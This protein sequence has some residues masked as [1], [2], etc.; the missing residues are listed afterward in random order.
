[1]SLFV[2][3]SYQ[4]SPL[5]NGQMTLPLDNY[6]D[7]ETVWNQKQEVFGGIFND[8]LAFN[9]RSSKFNHEILYNENDLIVLRLANNKHIVQESDFVT[10]KLQHN[11]SC[12]ILIDN[13]ADV[14]NMYIEQNTY[15]FSDV[16]VVCNILEA[17]FN[18]YL[19]NAQLKLKI[20]QRYKPQEFWEIVDSAKKGVGMVRF[21]FQ[22]PN[23]P[24]VKER[25]DAMLSETSKE[26]RSKETN[27][28][29]KAG[30]GE[31]LE[32]NKDNEKIA[33]LVRASAETG[34]NI[35]L[36]VNGLK[37]FKKVG[38]TVESVEIDN[39]EMSLSPDLLSTASQ[40]IV[41]I[42]NRFK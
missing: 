15:S 27:I 28:E 14:Q 30:E 11:P 37:H 3:F 18:S 1:M 10:K 24:K 2:V 13:R 4:F 17:T 6:P 12:L 32:L 42:L 9:N 8:N 34:N 5:F 7:R 38:E 26:L 19:R 31:S 16:S 25:I 33:D 21:T 23:L 39:L 20:Q 35:T 36:K 29:F 22:Y 40:K 41:E